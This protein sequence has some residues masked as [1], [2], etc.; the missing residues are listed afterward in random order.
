MKKLCD[1]TPIL[2]R[3]YPS[4]KKVNGHFECSAGQLYDLS[5]LPQVQL[6]G[7]QLKKKLY[8]DEDFV[9]PPLNNNRSLVK[10]KIGKLY[11]EFTPQG[12]GSFDLKIKLIDKQNRTLHSFLD[13]QN[14]RYADIEFEDLLPFSLGT[15]YS[16]RTIVRR[17][18]SEEPKWH[19]YELKEVLTK[20][21]L[22]L[23]L[24][25]RDRN[26]FQEH[27]RNL[28]FPSDPPNRQVTTTQDRDIEY[29]GYYLNEKPTSLFEVSAK[30]AATALMNLSISEEEISL[31]LKEYL[32]TTKGSLEKLKSEEVQAKILNTLMD[33]NR[34]PL[35]AIVNDIE[36]LLQ[37]AINNLKISQ[38]VA[39]EATPTDIMAENPWLIA[40][41]SLVNKTAMEIDQQLQASLPLNLNL[42]A[43]KTAYLEKLKEMINTLDPS[44]KKELAFFILNNKEHFLKKERHFFRAQNYSNETFSMHKLVVDILGLGVKENGK[45]TIH[46]DDNTNAYVISRHA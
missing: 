26:S 36:Q 11:M 20:L 33:K 32:E 17:S 9:I 42:K 35:K 2:D 4:Y 34:I 30:L 13:V 10:A 25:P 24:T 3:F 29:F 14:P 1:L 28:Y 31:V 41:D 6:N 5:Q 18:G 16:S 8:E 23:D 21:L 22:G 15:Y 44:Q 27:Y 38:E 39:Q 40:K 43:R 12:K 7:E 45:I 19:A 37:S 46:D